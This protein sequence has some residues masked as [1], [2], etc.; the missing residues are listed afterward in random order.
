MTEYLRIPIEE[1][2]N[3]Q[4]ELLPVYRAV[5]DSPAGRGHIALTY[6]CS[7]KRC[8]LAHIINTPRGVLI[9]YVNRPDT[10][11]ST[12]NMDS[13]GGGPNPYVGVLHPE[14]EQFITFF[15]CPHSKNLPY[16]HRQIA[17]DLEAHDHGSTVIL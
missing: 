5:V 7:P 8:A 1:I 4:D 16:T 2:E 11:R 10:W 6:R 13:M 3:R 12:R 15:Q 17:A 9:G 14:Y